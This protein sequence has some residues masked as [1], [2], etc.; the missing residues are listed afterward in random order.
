V[1]EFC[2]VIMCSAYQSLSAVKSGR[3]IRELG[4]AYKISE[5]TVRSRMETGITSTA[6]LRR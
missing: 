2:A 1:G 5:A 3:S 4:R 6:Q